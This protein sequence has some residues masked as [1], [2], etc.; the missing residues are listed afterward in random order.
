RPPTRNATPGSTLL[1]A[2]SL[3]LKKYSVL[4][5]NSN[6]TTAAKTPPA[7]RS[8][9][10]KARRRRCLGLIVSVTSATQQF[11]R[12]AGLIA[13][14]LAGQGDAMRP[15]RPRQALAAKRIPHRFIIKAG[16][17]LA[18]D[19]GVAQMEMIAMGM[20]ELG[21]R[22]FA[23]RRGHGRTG[24]PGDGLQQG[25]GLE[26][27]GIELGGIVFGRHGGPGKETAGPYS[28]AALLQICPKVLAQIPEKSGFWA[29]LL[30]CRAIC[31]KPVATFPDRAL[32]AMSPA[33]AA[34]ETAEAAPVAAKA[35]VE[36]A[37]KA[38][39]QGNRGPVIGIRVGIGVID[40]R[41]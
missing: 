3:G 14:A 21:D 29:R 6:T 18:I 7:A 34:M 40:R 25:Q 1:A 20:G 15:F 9:T 5:F 4:L 31:R 17:V 33:E 10:A 19:H 37:A 22:D 13:Q 2:T 24:Q 32:A 11:P 23:F 26:L 8:A 12:Q 38:K 39:A 16:G 36:T 28:P 27:Q 30:N 35:A 41:R